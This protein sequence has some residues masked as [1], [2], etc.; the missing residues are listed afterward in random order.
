LALFLKN[1]KLLDLDLLPDWPGVSSETFS[2]GTTA[3]GQKKRIQCVEWVL[4]QLFALWDPEETAKVDN[5]GLNMES[6]QT[7]GLTIA[8]QKIRPFFPPLDQV[9]SVNLRAALLRA[10]EQA[11]KNGA[12]GRDAILRKTMLDECKGE[13]LEEVLAAFST[14]VVKKVVEAETV[15]S[16]QHPVIALSLALENKGYKDD[17]TDLST[18]VLAH[19][20]ALHRLRDRK[21]EQ[22]AKF[23]DFADLLGVK[24]RSVAR[25]REEARHREENATAAKTVSDD[26][27]REMWRTVR[28]NW[29]GNEAW[30]ETLLHGD[31]VVK[32]DGPFGMPFDRVW[33]R[34]EQ[35]R[36]GE[37]EAKDSGLLEQLDGRVRLHRERLEKWRRYRRSMF[38]D[39]TGAVLSPSKARVHSRK[40]G[41]DLGFGAHENLQVGRVSPVKA[42]EGGDHTINAEYRELLDG[43]RNE[44][45]VV[46]KAPES[47]G[48]LQTSR[49]AHRRSSG[50]ERVSE[51]SELSDLEDDIPDAAPPPPQP[52]SSFK[53]KLEGVGRRP[54]RPRLNRPDL[55]SSESV[56]TTSRSDTN[57]TSL[58]EDVD[59]VIP[60]PS[61]H[62][63][64]RSPSGR[65]QQSPEEQQQPPVSP[66]QEAADQILA[67]MINVSPSPSKRSKP[68]HTLSL[69]ERT[70]LSMAPR[71]S[72]L[73]LEDEDL[74]DSPTMTGTTA[75]GSTAG[76]D[77]DGKTLVD[78]DDGEDLVSRT[79][80]SMAGFEKAQQKAKLE[81]RRSQRRSRLPP[82]RKEGSY[83]PK[84]DEEGQERTLLA[85]ELMGEED[86]EAVFRSRP[87]IMASPLPSPT[88]ELDF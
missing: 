31:A 36:L 33:R 22:A 63:R 24:E 60:R 52:V 21:E 14:A 6:C 64:D 79:R 62:S 48:F 58:P 80:R 73:F 57:R 78:E 83:F 49:K 35:D 8:F 82:Q 53:S 85:E 51:I 26:A 61:S 77:A 38:G 4:Y 67:S 42:I 1:L 56:K 59:N 12:L 28:N 76:V 68:R 20:V 9:Q 40:K 27:R 43:L 55:S 71:V 44:L 84:V 88:K 17:R 86:M 65:P 23:R 5:P 66:T 34:V 18:L 39:E 16:D 32:K 30:M 69:A 45:A 74:E 54:A 11:K 47:V 41:I 50:T 15:A 81:R 72:S 70:R 2:T 13:R 7:R 37:L 46:D 19:K 75:I 87:K 10:L 25:K 29:T 3:Q